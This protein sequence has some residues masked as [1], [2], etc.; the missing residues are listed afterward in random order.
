M[1][2]VSGVSLDAAVG[3]SANLGE[4]LQ[5]GDVLSQSD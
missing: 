1:V 4:R 5:K 2:S 3:M